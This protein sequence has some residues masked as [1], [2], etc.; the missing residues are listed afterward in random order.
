MSSNGYVTTL[1]KGQFSP[2]FFSAAGAGMIAGV[3]VNGAV[4][5]ATGLGT[6]TM[7]DLYE[8]AAAVPLYPYL[9]AASLLQISSTSANDTAAG[10]GARSVFITGL[11][12]NYNPI[13]ETLVT[14]GVSNVVTV[15]S[16]LRVNNAFVT[17]SGTFATTNLGDITLQK[18]GGG[19]I[20]GIIRANV[21]RLGSAVFTV[22]NGF[23]TILNS[24]SG[25]VLGALANVAQVGRA[26]NSN[27]A[28]NTGAIFNLSGTG[29]FE[30]AIPGNVILP[31]KTD[32]TFRVTSVG[33]AA[34]AISGVLHLVTLNNTYFS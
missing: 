20:L 15:N 32:I 23:T 28:M 19:N 14:N 1:Q 21:G 6:G 30:E 31:Q 3:S 25:S 24:L 8:N 5:H 11:D 2:D 22:P 27:G 17:S 29:S 18:S 10:T 16:Y 13:S 26:D 12:L 33:Q 9:A 34:T 4:G 7:Y